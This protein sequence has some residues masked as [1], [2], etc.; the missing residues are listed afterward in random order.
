MEALAPFACQPPPMDPPPLPYLQAKQPLAYDVRL[1]AGIV[2]AGSKREATV[3]TTSLRH[4]SWT[5]P[6]VRAVVSC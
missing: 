1:S 3:A 2:P 5:F 6:Q 4:L